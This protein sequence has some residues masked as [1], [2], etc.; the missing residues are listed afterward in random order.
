MIFNLEGYENTVTDRASSVGPP[1]DGA[2]T[3]TMDKPPIWLW[4]L[5]RPKQ[6]EKYN[7][8]LLI[9]HKEKK[10]ISS[11]GKTNSLFALSSNFFF[12]QGYV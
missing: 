7:Y 10:I 6:K 9:V 5:S 4:I 12:L 11:L 8:A 1:S 3:D 2:Y